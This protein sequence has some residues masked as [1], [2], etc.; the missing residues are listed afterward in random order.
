MADYQLNLSGDRELITLMKKMTDLNG[1]KQ[2]IKEAGA[3]MDQ[4]SAKATPV[5]TGNLRRSGL[6]ELDDD[7]LGVQKGYNTN[8]AAYVEFGTRFFAGRFYLKR[9]YLAGKETL[10][11]S[12]QRWVT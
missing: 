1:V 10:M 4:V 9:G 2:A 7:G 6:L 3:Q 12:L 5:Q 11:T 8:Y